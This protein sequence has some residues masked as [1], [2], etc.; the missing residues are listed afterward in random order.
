MKYVSGLFESE[1][2]STT[3][4]VCGLVNRQLRE[5]EA[6]AFLIELGINVL[7]HIE[8]DIPVV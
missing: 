6:N 3:K 1:K 8:I 5:R 7:V 2:D 4:S